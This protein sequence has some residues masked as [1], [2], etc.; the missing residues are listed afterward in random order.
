MANLVPWTDWKPYR[1]FPWIEYCVVAA[2]LESCPGVPVDTSAVWTE[3]RWRRKP[4]AANQE[5]SHD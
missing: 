1:F 3:R 4:L 2:E 5:N